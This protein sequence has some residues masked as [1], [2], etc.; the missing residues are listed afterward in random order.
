M[1][2]TQAAIYFLKN[3]GSF[4]APLSED[5]KVRKGEK[6]RNTLQRVDEKSTSEDIVSIKVSTG[7]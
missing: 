2:I 3:D 6:T 1:K 4:F 7:N 5:S